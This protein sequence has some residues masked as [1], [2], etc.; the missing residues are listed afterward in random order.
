MALCS[1]LGK[2]F[3]KQGRPDFCSDGCVTY[4]FVEYQHPYSGGRFVEEYIEKSS[5]FKDSTRSVHAEEMVL[6]DI[7]MAEHNKTW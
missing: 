5:R 7:V 3:Y 6:R 4:C 1:Q 2:F